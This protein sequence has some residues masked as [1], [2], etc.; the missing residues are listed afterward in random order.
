MVT[1]AVIGPFDPNEANNIQKFLNHAIRSPRYHPCTPVLNLNRNWLNLNLDGMA[2]VE[3][4]PGLLYVY[5][6]P[7][8]S[9]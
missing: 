1:L 6:H 7:K 3:N 2:A 9:E 5:H 4:N 8:I